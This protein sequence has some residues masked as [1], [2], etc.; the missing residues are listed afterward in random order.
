MYTVTSGVTVPKYCRGT[1]LADRE[2]ST[3]LG[4]QF[5]KIIR[6][7]FSYL[8]FTTNKLLLKR[9]PIGGAVTMANPD[10][11]KLHWI[12]N[13]SHIRC[14]SL[15]LLFTPVSKQS[16]HKEAASA[17]T[18][19]YHHIKSLKIRVHHVR[20]GTYSG[21]FNESGMT[22]YYGQCTATVQSV[23]RSLKTPLHRLLSPPTLSFYYFLAN[24]EK[25]YC[26]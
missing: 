21:I 13:A 9:S 7:S 23:P 3:I 2:I 20:V 10:L 24:I 11:S 19:T 18:C 17:V 25:Q 16:K 14:K 8:L 22:S 12:G 6:N 26:Y 1:F 4:S 15:M 5:M